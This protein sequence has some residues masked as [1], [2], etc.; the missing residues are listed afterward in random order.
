[1]PHDD[2]V[3]LSGIYIGADNTALETNTL[4]EAFKAAQE[5]S[6]I[7]GTDSMT[8]EE[9]NAE[10]TAYRREKQIA[11]ITLASERA[12]AED[13]LLPEEDLAWANM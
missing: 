12:L 13:W 8:M 7:N 6:V 10:I 1:M 3:E 9:I 2:F 11:D 5:Q 4:K